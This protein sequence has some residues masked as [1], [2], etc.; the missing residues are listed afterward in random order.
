[1]KKLLI[2]L[3]LLLSLSALSLTACTPTPSGS[4]G[5]SESVSQSESTVY[6]VVAKQPEI[7]VKDED[8]ES[9]VYKDL[10][11]ISKNGQI[12]N[13]S[14]TFTEEYFDG[15]FNLTCTYN[16]LSATVKIIVII[17]M[18]IIVNLL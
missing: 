11:E 4:D 12:I 16:G 5:Q 10:F 18:P 9:L 13:A 3:L 6:T 14:A 8:V 2:A 1:M 15:G 7:T 17:S